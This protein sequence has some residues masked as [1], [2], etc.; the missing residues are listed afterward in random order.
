LE[1]GSTSFRCWTSGTAALFMC[2]DTWA[3]PVAGEPRHPRPRQHRTGALGGSSMTHVRRDRR[4]VGGAVGTQAYA[5]AA[6]PVSMQGEVGCRP[7]SRWQRV[8]L[9]GREPGDGWSGPTVSAGGAIV[10]GQDEIAV[11]SL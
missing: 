9:L 3:H 11:F 8:G 7:P 6:L 5:A 2:P 10:S 1:T 4:P